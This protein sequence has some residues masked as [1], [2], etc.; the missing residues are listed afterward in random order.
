MTNFSENEILT[1]KSKLLEFV[2][3]PTVTMKGDS[4]TFKNVQNIIKILKES[5]VDK[6]PIIVAE[7]LHKIPPI[8]F[9]NLHVSR[10]LRELA[11]IRSQT[12][13]L[14][15][16]WESNKEEMKDELTKE[17][18]YASATWVYQCA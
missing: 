11:T 6:M 17:F 8:T 5:A 14:Y 7:D 1:A 12:N 9:V 10:I 16:T 13:T 18:N 3:I 2:K 4:K 15:C